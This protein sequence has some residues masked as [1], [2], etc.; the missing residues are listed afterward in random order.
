MTTPVSRLVGGRDIQGR[1]QAFL[2][3]GEAADHSPSTINT[4]R[5]VLGE[6][7][8][9]VKQF[10]VIMP[11]DIDEQHVAAYIIHKRKT[12]NGVSVS[13]Y[14][15]HVR[16]WFNWMVARGMIKQSPCAALKTPAI[17]K[18]VIKPVT[19]EQVNNMLSCCTDY[20]SGI[21]NKATY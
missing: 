5:K 12:C 14:Y 21:R 1:V 10:G 7:A 3:Y 20:F 4:Y 13:T 16:A 9:F 18:T 17:P 15:R 2:N 11:E 8:N 19:G 6:F